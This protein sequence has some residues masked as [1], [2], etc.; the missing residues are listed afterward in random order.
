MTW[1]QPTSTQHRARDLARVGPGCRALSARSCAPSAIGLPSSQLATARQVDVRRAQQHRRAWLAVADAGAQRADELAALARGSRSS[2]SCR[3]SKAYARHV[4]N[5]RRARVSP[6]AQRGRA[7]YGPHAP[8]RNGPR[9][10]W[11]RRSAAPRQCDATAHRDAELRNRAEPRARRQSVPKLA[12]VGE[13]GGERADLV[14]VLALDHDADHGLRARGAQHDAAAV[15]ELRDSTSVDGI[16]HGL[17][18]A[19]DRRVLAL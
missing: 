3:Q 12:T 9:R 14:A 6:Q 19:S 11:R 16:A 7:A 4:E 18:R 8:Q 1:L 10:S 5:S 17:D 2:S 15:A 13:P